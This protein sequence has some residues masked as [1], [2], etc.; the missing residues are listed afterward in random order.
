MG[1]HCL[2]EE[3]AASIRR[4]RRRGGNSLHLVLILA[5]GF[6][7]VI[8][9]FDVAYAALHAPLPCPDPDR[10]AVAGDG[11]TRRLLFA[12]GRIAGL[13]ACAFAKSLIGEEQIDDP[14]WSMSVVAGR[15]GSSL[16]V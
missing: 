8:G 15:T 6:G 11:N 4:I 12:F 14:C 13:M 16:N 5:V 9:I 7:C 2:V 1:L 10:I 3:A